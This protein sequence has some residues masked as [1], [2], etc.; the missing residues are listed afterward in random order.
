MLAAESMVSPIF[1]WSRLHDAV[2]QSSD[3][4]HHDERHV[5]RNEVTAVEVGIVVST[6]LSNRNV[7]L[8]GDKV[9]VRNSFVIFGKNAQLQ[10]FHCALYLGAFRSSSSGL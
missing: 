7:W 2:E 5:E 4:W 1:S 6:L 9:E 3:S 10:R 8:S